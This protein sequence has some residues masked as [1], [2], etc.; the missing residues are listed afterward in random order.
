MEEVRWVL[1][2]SALVLW[3]LWR[4]IQAE[5]ESFVNLKQVVLFMFN[6]KVILIFSSPILKWNIYLLIC[7][8]GFSRWCKNVKNAQKLLVLRK[9]T[10]VVPTREFGLN[11]QN[12][13]C[14]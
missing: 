2:S 14:W 11:V 5:G 13:H 12:I 3:F 7:M 10:Q 8:K 4:T 1:V 6:K 9:N